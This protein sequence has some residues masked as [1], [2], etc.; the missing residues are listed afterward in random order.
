LKKSITHNF[1]FTSPSFFASLSTFSVIA[2]S[3]IS[4]DFYNKIMYEKS[5]MFLNIKLIMFV[6]LCFIFFLSGALLFRMSTFSRIKVS[7]VVNRHGFLVYSNLFIIFSLTLIYFLIYINYPNFYQLIL[8]GEASVFRDFATSSGLFL[9]IE[10]GT[11]LVIIMVFLIY[12]FYS[13]M[14]FYKSNRKFWKFRLL[15]VSSNFLFLILITILQARYILMPYLVS[16]IYVYL[17]K[18]VTA[19]G[20]NFQVFF[21][22]TTIVIFSIVF[23]FN[24][25]SYIRIGQGSFTGVNLHLY[26]YTVASVNRLAYILNGDLILPFSGSTYVIFRNIWFTPVIGNIIKTY[27]FADLIG[28]V[29]PGASNYYY[30]LRSSLISADLQPSYVWVTVFGQL[31]GEWGWFGF[32]YFYFYGFFSQFIYYLYSKKNLVGII[33]YPIIVFSIG[34]WIGDNYLNMPDFF[35]VFVLSLLLNIFVKIKL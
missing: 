28:L 3:F 32:I 2:A 14:S 16:L 27:N 11:I 17:S 22:F 10:I 20:F 15:I 13:Y 33:M 26:G 9:G 35:I 5:M 30:Y 6:L 31:Y 23:M 25:V 34:F 8:L 18:L 29:L 7:R 12:S 19:K 1:N 24:L 21:V 4:V